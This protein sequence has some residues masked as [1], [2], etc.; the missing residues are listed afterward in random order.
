M[1]Q[2]KIPKELLSLMER[3][4]KTAWKLMMLDAQVQNMLEDLGVADTPEYINFQNNYGCMLTTEPSNYHDET[5]KIIE[6][7]INS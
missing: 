1:K 2:K 4:E 7:I 3:R 5:T 6:K